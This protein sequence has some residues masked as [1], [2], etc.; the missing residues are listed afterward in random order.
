MFKSAI[1]TK[2]KGNILASSGITLE[3]TLTLYK[4][5]KDKKNK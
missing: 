3:Q 5:D 1:K 4:S 2:N